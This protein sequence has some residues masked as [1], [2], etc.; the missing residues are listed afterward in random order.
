MKTDDDIAGVIASVILLGVIILGTIG[1]VM[2]IFK[3]FGA[4]TITGMEVVRAIGILFAPLGAIV[5]WF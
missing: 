4:D 1:W 2:N 3:L 5:G